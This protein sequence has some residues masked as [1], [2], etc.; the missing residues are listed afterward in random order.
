VGQDDKLKRSLTFDFILL[1]RQGGGNPSCFFLIY[2]KNP[3]IP[4]VLDFPDNPESLDNP[5]SPEIPENPETKN[6]RDNFD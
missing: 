1:Y 2:R 3:E 5:E 4:E 6:L